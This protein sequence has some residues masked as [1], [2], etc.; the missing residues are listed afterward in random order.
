MVTSSRRL[1][2]LV[3][4]DDPSLRNALSELMLALG[5]AP[6]L[7]ETRDE[8]LEIVST[9][10]IDFSICDLHVRA[11]SGIVIVAQLRARIERLPVIFMSGDFTPD[12][13]ARA[14]DLGA[15]GTLDK[16]LDLQDLR[17]ALSH[18]ITSERL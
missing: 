15:Y 1:N 17:E 11:D 4:D 10:T 12:L 2:A 3:V 16:P 6:W 7:A 13:I 9:T 18:L 8:A 5:H 14:E